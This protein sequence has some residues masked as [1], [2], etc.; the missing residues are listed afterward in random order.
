M[1]DGWRATDA[2]RAYSAG[3]RLRPV[4]DA[5]EPAGAWSLRRERCGLLQSWSAKRAEGADW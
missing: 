4:R 3:P 5:R 2:H 1:G